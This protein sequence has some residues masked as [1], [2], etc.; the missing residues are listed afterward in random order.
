VKEKKEKKDAEQE[1]LL[2]LDGFVPEKPGAQKKFVKFGGKK[3]MIKDFL[4]VG[5]GVFFQL[6]ANEEEL[7]GKSQVEQIRLARDNIKLLVPGMGEEVV[8]QLSIRQVTRI[9]E[10]ST[11]SD[12]LPP[13]VGSG[14]DPDSGS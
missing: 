2:D 6:M 14:S 5:L 13:A 12:T 10:M 7:E 1:R 8:N 4:D 3:Y 11:G 9:I